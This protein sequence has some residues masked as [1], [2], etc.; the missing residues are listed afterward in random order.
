M[1]FTLSRTTSGLQK[2]VACDAT[3]RL[4]TGGGDKLKG[5]ERGG[6]GEKGKI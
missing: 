1:H 4:M 2:M 3:A 6:G 5:G